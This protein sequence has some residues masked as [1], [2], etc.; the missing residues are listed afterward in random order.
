MTSQNIVLSSWDTLYIPPVTL[1]KR[2][3]LDLN[4]YPHSSYIS[5]L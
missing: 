3:R 2:K 5:L 1:Y 4:I